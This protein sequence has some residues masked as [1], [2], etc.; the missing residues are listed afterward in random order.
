MPSRSPL[1]AMRSRTAVSFEVAGPSS[2]D[3]RLR[4]FRDDRAVSGSMTRCQSPAPHV[5]LLRRRTNMAEGVVL[6]SLAAVLN[7][8]CQHLVDRQ[9]PNTNTNT[10]LA[11]RGRES[12]GDITEGDISHL[13]GDRRD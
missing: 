9:R 7:G 5:F 2:T 10:E 13:R 4:P 12:G 1:G 6:R 3:D 8:L 11:Q